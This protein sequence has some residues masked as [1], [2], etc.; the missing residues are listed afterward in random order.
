MAP[1]KVERAT[2]KPIALLSQDDVNVTWPVIEEE[3]VVFTCFG[4]RKVYKMRYD[5]KNAYAIIVTDTTCVAVTFL[6][7]KPD[8][9]RI[10]IRSVFANIATI[11]IK[12]TR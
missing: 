11:L 4:R 5:T 9:T 7:R 3:P 1:S 6:F 10:K 2:S 12:A 8:F